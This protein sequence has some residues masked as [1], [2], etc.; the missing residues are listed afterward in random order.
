MPTY[1]AER[2]ITGMTRDELTAKLD[3]GQ[4]LLDEMPEVDWVRSYIS[5]EEG[6]MYCEYIAP[7]E[8]VLFELGEKMGLPVDAVSAIELEIS[9]EMFV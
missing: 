6:K 9:S 1:V 2:S 7:N 3:I 4:D 8:Q 5:L